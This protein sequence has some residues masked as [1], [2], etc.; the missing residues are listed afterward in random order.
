VDVLNL[1]SSAKFFDL[2]PTD[3]EEVNNIKLSLYSNLA[4]VNKH[5]SSSQL[6]HDGVLMRS[7][8]F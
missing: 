3:E 8:N 4:Q 7:L 2:N 1:V 5:A 6:C